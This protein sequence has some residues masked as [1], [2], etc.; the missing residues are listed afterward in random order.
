MVLYLS[1]DNYG[2][3]F[4]QVNKWTDTG[5]QIYGCRQPHIFY[6]VESEIENS[7]KCFMKRIMV[8]KVI[9]Q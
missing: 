1:G 8:E 2:A 4:V 7:K 6:K 5:E 9:A 3:I